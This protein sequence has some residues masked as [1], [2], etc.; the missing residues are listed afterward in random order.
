MA[1]CPGQIGAK[2]NKGFLRG[3]EYVASWRQEA[4]HKAEL[5]E[6]FLLRVIGTIGVL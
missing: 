4:I 5:G 1:Y 2:I 3:R 6:P